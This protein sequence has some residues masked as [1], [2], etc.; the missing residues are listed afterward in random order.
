MAKVADYISK[1][2]KRINHDVKLGLIPLSVMQ[3]YEIY[4]L[5]LSVCEYEIRPMKRYSIVAN[6]CKISVS[7]VRKSIREMQKT[8]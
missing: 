3:N 1:N 2:I 4:K 5:Y 7:T 6:R 8:A